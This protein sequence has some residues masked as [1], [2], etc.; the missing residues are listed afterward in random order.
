MFIA[1]TTTL[2]G[3]ACTLHVDDTGKNMA[4]NKKSFVPLGQQLED[5]EE[6]RNQT[7]QEMVRAYKCPSKS[8]ATLGSVSD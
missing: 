6:Q 8:I 5:E 3:V 7:T 2:E 4:V 1:M